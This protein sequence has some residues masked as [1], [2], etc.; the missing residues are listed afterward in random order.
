MTVFSKHLVTGEVVARARP[1]CYTGPY[2][3]ASMHILAPTVNIITDEEQT[4]T[5]LNRKRNLSESKATQLRQ[6]YRSS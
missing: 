6:M 1:L 3:P 4:Y 2:N 5:A